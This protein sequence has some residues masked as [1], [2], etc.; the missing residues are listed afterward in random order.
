M[1]LIFVYHFSVLSRMYLLMHIKNTQT[2]EVWIIKKNSCLQNRLLRLLNYF[3]S[4]RKTDILLLS[5]NKNIKKKTLKIKK[6][7][8]LLLG[9]K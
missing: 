1:F 6:I 8:Y 4:V 9:T 5:S 7:I 3:L 2:E